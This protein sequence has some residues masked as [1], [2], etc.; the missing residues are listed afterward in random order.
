MQRPRPLTW[1]IV[2]AAVILA[3]AGLWF[4]LNGQGAARL[5]AVVYGLGSLGALAWL[6]A[7]LVWWRHHPWVAKLSQ[8]LILGWVSGLLI[9]LCLQLGFTSA[10][11]MLTGAWGMATA[12]MLGLELLRVLLSPGWAILGV[13]RT[14]LDEAIR[15]KMALI[16]VV[17]IV[18][19][20]PFLPFMLGGETRL[21][22]KLESF[23]TYSL[24]L[25]ATLLSVM[26]ILLAVRTV[27]SELGEKQAFLTLTK[28][29]SRTGYLAGKWIGIMSL[30][31]LL[32]V[33]SGIGVYAFVKVLEQQRPMDSADAVAVYEQVLTARSSAEPRPVDPNLLNIDY[34]QKLQEM[35]DRGADPTLYGQR[36][37][38]DTFVNPAMKQ[39]M[40]LDIMKQW[41][42]I[43][44]RNRQTYRFAGLAEAKEAGETIQLRIKPK[45]SRAAGD[46][47]VRL[48]LRVNDRPYANPLP[49]PML[50][51][52]PVPL[53]RNNTFHIV[54]LLS[55]DIRDDGTLDLTIINTGAEVDQ[56]ALTFKPGEGL[57]VFYKVGSF[58]GNLAKGVL[59]MWVRLGFLAALGLAAATFLGFPVACLLCFLIFFAAVGSD[60]L[61][62]SLS[63]YASIP[64]DEVPWWDKI[65]LTFG[66]FTGHLQAG[67]IFDAFK[68]V[69]RVVGES[70]TFVVPPMARYSPTP[71]IAYGRAVEAPMI[72]GVFWRIGVVSTG[73]VALA[74][75]FF[76][77][78]REVAQVQV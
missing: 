31:A 43:A 12:F 11:I 29:I 78:R 67:E 8:L 77:S 25:I 32:L 46:N 1:W 17:M 15:M 39:A 69:I 76:F 7:G 73:V 3:T 70:F 41:L 68:L 65:W 28:P 40:Q 51:G 63:S 18:L 4:V 55:D 59:V 10:A 16:F 19:V 47:M 56:T 60:Y 36:G 45:A 48:A 35:R 66:K 62:E 23:L 33:V 38:P 6:L 75:A 21:Q 71:L 58:R 22:Y 9:G 14:L 2:Y 5:G 61:S 24:T 54:T 44:P 64:R 34:D 74:A 37:D 27:T 52:K 20:V 26:T 49:D 53:V 30:N 57:E 50:F 72:V 42:T 13:A